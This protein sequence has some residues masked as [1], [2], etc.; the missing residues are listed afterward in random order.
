MNNQIQNQYIPDYVSPPGETLLELIEEKGMSQAE[1]ALRIGRPKKT[2]NEIIL[3][4]ASITP[5]TALQLERALN[6]PSTFW[7]SREK[8][9]RE[10]LSNKEEK[11]RLKD[12]VAWLRE[13]P[14]KDLISQEWI[15]PFNNKVDQLTELLNFFGIAS[16]EQ[17][18]NVWERFSEAFCRSSIFTTNRKALSAWLRQGEIE[19]Q[20]IYCNAYSS[21]KFKNTLKKIRQLTIEP[22]DIF[23]PKLVHLCA[24]VGIAVVF[25]PELPK[26]SI[27]G[28]TRWLTHDKALIQLSLRYKTDDQLWFTFFHEAGHILLH[29]KRDIFLEDD[30]IDNEKEQQA[31][32]FA[33][34][35]LIPYIE[36]ENFLRELKPGRISKNNICAFA[37]SIGI[38]PG[39]VVGRLQHD[40]YLPY[41]HCNGLKQK[42]IWKV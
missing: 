8:Q 26:I 1:L 5:D 19:A 23:Q 7:N 22:P 40:T 3:G 30:S 17:W 33:S 28:A 16:P 32:K 36:F 10:F 12:K 34:D 15:R 20:E 11:L 13:F 9:Y 35:I 39:I 27:S 37:E 31:N 14:I 29:G 24:E 18:D 21:S 42:F 41:T 6:V 4:K 2:I 25:L 38:S